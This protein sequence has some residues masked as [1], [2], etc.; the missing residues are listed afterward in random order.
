MDIFSARMAYLDELGERRATI[1]NLLVTESCFSKILH[2]FRTIRY[3]Y[4]LSRLDKLDQQMTIYDIRLTMAKEKVSVFPA[5]SVKHNQG[6][7]ESEEIS[8]EI[9]EFM[10]NNQIESRTRIKAKSR[11]KR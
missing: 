6:L 1:I 9:N 10:E 3:H 7:R 5:G 11:K 4:E 8:Q 2:P